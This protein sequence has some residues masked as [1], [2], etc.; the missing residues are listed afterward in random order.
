MKITLRAGGIIRSGPERDL[1]DDYLKRAKGLARGTGFS[2][3]TEEQIDLRSAKPVA[4]KPKPCCINY[5]LARSFV[6]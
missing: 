6:F 2:N 4:R 3:V 1:I 5:L